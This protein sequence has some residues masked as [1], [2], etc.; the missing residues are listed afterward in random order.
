LE[1][2]GWVRNRSDG[3]EVELQGEPCSVEAFERE[4]ASHLPPGTVVD[5]FTSEEIAVG[6]SGPFRIEAGASEGPLRTAVPPDAALCDHCRGEVSDPNNRRCEYP[7]TTCA[8]CGPRFSVITAMPF[9]RNAT[10]MHSFAM[11]AMCAAEYRNPVD[12]RFHAQTIACPNCGPRVWCVDGHGRVLGAQR[13]AVCIV[14]EALK[15]GQIVAL[16]GIG[17]YQLLCDATSSEAVRRLRNRKRRPSKPLA[18]LVESLE[19]ARQLTEVSALEAEALASRAN[20][21]VLVRWRMGTPACPSWS[22][23]GTGK[24]AHPPENLAPE[25]HPGLRDVGLMLPS[26]PLHWLIAH[27]SGRPLVATSGNLEG[28]PLVVEVAEAESRLAGVADVWLHHDRPIANGVDDSVV[29][30]IANR[31]VTLRMARGFAPLVLPEWPGKRRGFPILATGGHLKNAIAFDNGE[32]TVLGPHIGD[33]DDEATR[34]RFVANVSAFAR[35]FGAEPR[36]IMHDRHPEYFTTR[37]AFRRERPACAVQHHQAHVLAASWEL[38]WLDREVLGFAWDGTGFGTDSTIWGGETLRVQG[39]RCEREGHCR[40]FRLPGGEA[41]IREP[42]RVAAVLLR[43]AVGDAAAR[44]FASRVGR[45]REFERLF[46]ISNANRFSPIC[47]SI[48]RLFDG[49]AAL[50][51]GVTRCDFEGQAA[52]LLEHACETDG[53]AYRLSTD[54]RQLDWRPLIQQLWRDVQADVPRGRIAMRFHQTLAQFV[55]ETA[56]RF[57]ELPV[58]LCGGA[59]QNRVLVESI[60]EQWP[61]DLGGLGWP[62]RIPPNDGGLAAGQLAFG[63]FV[64]ERE[65]MRGGPE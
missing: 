34:Q 63:R 13:E 37:W 1:L 33:L 40:P 39:S 38:G 18:V 9:E 47:T 50:V 6:D 7:L 4:L 57:R 52:M 61:P 65:T 26:S 44:E 51:L 19:V 15:G 20:P 58:A 46:T 36:L 22:A 16:R 12:R 2:S 10:T 25:I 53:E 27:Q 29:R 31:V 41:A 49:V 5:R 30:L 43:D 21:I 32:Q 35:L 48:G 11:C 64:A 8:A 23:V 3:V 60:V 28:E 17:G 59:F 45:R 42:W 56:R 54:D 14:V 55:I 62:S 24:S